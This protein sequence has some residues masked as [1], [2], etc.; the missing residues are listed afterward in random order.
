MGNETGGMA[1][2][3]RVSNLIGSFPVN[4]NT[5]LPAISYLEIHFLS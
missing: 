1:G 5:T 2:D 3:I 4:F